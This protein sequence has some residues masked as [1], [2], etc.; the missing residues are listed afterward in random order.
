MPSKSL[1]FKISLHL[2]IDLQ[3]KCTCHVDIKQQ[4]VLDLQPPSWN[5][6]RHEKKDAERSSVNFHLQEKFVENIWGRLSVSSISCFSPSPLPYGGEASPNLILRPVFPS[7]HDL[8]TIRHS[9]STSAFSNSK[10]CMKAGG[11]KQLK[12]QL[13][14]G[15]DQ[16][17]P[18]WACCFMASVSSGCGICSSLLPAKSDAKMTLWRNVLSVTTELRP[19]WPL[20]SSHG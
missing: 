19:L 13:L 7:Q 5:Q 8:K 10:M 4:V 18:A 15:N 14:R 3:W 17:R 20:F 11:W 6:Q 9:I 16:T 1:T 12:K 2:R